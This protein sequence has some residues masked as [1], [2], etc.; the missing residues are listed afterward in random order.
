[1]L[2]LVFHQKISLAESLA[3]VSQDEVI[4]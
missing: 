1:V 4:L 2:E 3:L